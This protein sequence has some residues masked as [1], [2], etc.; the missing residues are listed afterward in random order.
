[1]SS[2]KAT[3]CALP[4]INPVRRIIQSAF[5]LWPKSVPA[6]A[7][8]LSSGRLPDRKNSPSPGEQNWSIIT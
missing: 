7:S 5:A 3:K 8:A 6:V 1:L 2:A 4:V